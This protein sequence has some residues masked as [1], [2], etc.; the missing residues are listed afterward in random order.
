[1]QCQHGND[2]VNKDA[3]GRKAVENDNVPHPDLLLLGARLVNEEAVHEGLLA[4][5]VGVLVLAEVLPQK[6][7]TCY[8]GARIRGLRH[9][10]LGNAP[11]TAA[12]RERGH[13]RT[14]FP[15]PTA[16]RRPGRRA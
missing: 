13:G 2:L 7:A 1:M 6:V 16:S 14:Q 5:Q 3:A 15:W 8:V 9:Q 10:Q 12:S 11:Q 4:I